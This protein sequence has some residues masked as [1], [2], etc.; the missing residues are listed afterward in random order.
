MKEIMKRLRRREARTAALSGLP[1]ASA[2]TSTVA[3]TGLLYQNSLPM[4]TCPGSSTSNQSNTG[5][6]AGGNHSDNRTRQTSAWRTRGGRATA[7]ALAA[8]G[9][10]GYNSDAK[11]DP[12]SNSLNGL[13]SAHKGSSARNSS[14]SSKAHS[15]TS[16]LSSGKRGF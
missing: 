11:P 8:S 16:A 2:S 15:R 6:N 1:P 4:T 13:L 5:C 7:T 3:A 12:Q 14:T 9:T 10:A